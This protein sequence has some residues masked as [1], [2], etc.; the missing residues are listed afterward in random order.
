MEQPK[1]CN[2]CKKARKKFSWYFVVMFYATIL[3]VW[4]QIELIK[5]IKNLF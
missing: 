1:K 5:F 3:L 2:F 4:G